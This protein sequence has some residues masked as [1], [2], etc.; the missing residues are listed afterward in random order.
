MLRERLTNTLSFVIR[1][2][3]RVFTRSGGFLRD[4]RRFNSGPC[5][6]EPTAQYGCSGKWPIFQKAHSALK[7]LLHGEGL[8]RTGIVIGIVVAGYILIKLFIGI[9]LDPSST[10]KQRPFRIKSMVT[11][12]STSHVLKAIVASVPVSIYKI[13]L[14]DETNGNIVLGEAPS[15]TSY[16]FFYPVFVR[17]EGAET[18]VEVGIKSKGWQVGPI[19]TRHHDRCFSWVRAT[20]FAE[21]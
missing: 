4:G 13:E 1:S 5:R 10:V 19:V 18:R 9:I 20:I 7:I 16:G 3:A 14:F 15:L 17:S 11:G 12:V 6:P 21:S 2:G 8:M